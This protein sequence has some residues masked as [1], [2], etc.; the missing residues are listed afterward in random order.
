MQRSNRNKIEQVSL[1]YELAVCTLLSPRTSMHAISAS[2]KSKFSS[3]VIIARRGKPYHRIK[4]A[5]A[6]FD[7]LCCNPASAQN[8]EPLP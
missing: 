1:R 7:K 4:E 2:R 3:T 6:G 5:E 8:A